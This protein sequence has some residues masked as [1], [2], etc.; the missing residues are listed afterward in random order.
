MAL[1][2]ETVLLLYD[3]RSAEAM[4]TGERAIEAWQT[5]GPGRAQS[6][7]GTA[8]GYLALDQPAKALELFAG[9]RED[10]PE[11]ASDVVGHGLQALAYELL[12]DGERADAVFAEYLERV[13][14][15]PGPVFV[16]T[17]HEIRGN[18]AAMRGE[19]ETAITEFEHA[20]AL[21]PFANPATPRLW[22]V[23]IDAY[24]E[25]GRVEDAERLLERMLEHG[26]GRVFSPPQY[27]SSHYRL[28]KIHE[29]RGDAERAAQLY[30]KFVEYWK[31]GDMKRE[32]IADAE[33]FLSTQSGQ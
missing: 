30:A 26:P 24:H 6:K 25:A 2:F 15:L 20:A 27:V 9:A 12:G 7:L 31:N 29:E 10:D 13:A 22:G 3:G 32:A 23:M 5:P 33:R 4:A 14:D 8:A 21:H 19:L 1:G 16:A 17:T 11:Q 28:G 18:L